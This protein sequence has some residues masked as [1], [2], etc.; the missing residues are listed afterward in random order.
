VDY[1]LF[2]M[3]AVLVML[4]RLEKRPGPAPTLFTPPIFAGTTFVSW[5]RVSSLPSRG[6]ASEGVLIW[7]FLGQDG[8]SGTK[9]DDIGASRG[10]TSQGSVAWPWAC[11]T[12]S[13]LGSGG[14]LVCLFISFCCSKK[15][16]DSRKSLA[17]IEFQKVPET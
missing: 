4:K 2:T 14:P 3:V 12:W 16:D 17:L 15:N 11:T 9:T 10:Q 13:L 5:F 8:Q 7:D 6:N 1:S